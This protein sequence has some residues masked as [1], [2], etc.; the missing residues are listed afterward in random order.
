MDWYGGWL[1]SRLRVVKQESHLHIKKALCADGIMRAGPSFPFQKKLCARKIIPLTVRKKAGI[2]P[3]RARFLTHELSPLSPKNPSTMDTTP[4]D[5]RISRT[6]GKLTISDSSIQRSMLLNFPVLPSAPSDPKQGDVYLNT[7]SNITFVYTSAGWEEFGANVTTGT[8]D[9]L[10]VATSLTSEGTTALDGDVTIGGMVDVDGIT[11]ISDT[12]ASSSTTTG[13]LTTAGGVGIAGDVHIGGDITVA[14]AGPWDA[15]TV[16]LAVTFDGPCVTVPVAE[17]IT[18]RKSD[19]VVTI[20]LPAYSFTGSSTPGV[21]SS[22]SAL[23]VG[24]L[25][26]SSHNQPLI[27]T[28]APTAGFQIGAV[29]SVSFLGV[30]SV[31][32]ATPAGTFN[33]TAIDWPLQ[34]ITYTLD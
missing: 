31:A 17:T 28:I 33:T 34:C 23:P 3:T 12:T 22:T 15:E 16:A 25:P 10:T 30:I 29:F 14:G 19:G 20:N 24:F 2:S 18:F 26:T 21:L 6:L 27:V 5:R 32:P 11:A 9:D 7:T 8:F 1:D 4:G 13:S